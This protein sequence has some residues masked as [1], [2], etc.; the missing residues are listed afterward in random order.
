[1]PGETLSSDINSLSGITLYVNA[2]NVYI[3]KYCYT[4]RLS[5][6]ILVDTSITTT[7][8]YQQIYINNHP[9]PNHSYPLR[10]N[11]YSLALVWRAVD[12][13]AIPTCFLDQNI[14]ITQ[15]RSELGTDAGSGLVAELGTGTGTGS[16]LGQQLNP[17]L[18]IATGGG[19]GQGY[20][21]SDDIFNRRDMW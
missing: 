19:D 5:I 4:L 12:T 2:Y 6:D 16:G 10:I 3:L 1:M 20:Y 14:R 13:A 15:P 7:P 21:S 17:G 11:F 9:Y 8:F 18:G